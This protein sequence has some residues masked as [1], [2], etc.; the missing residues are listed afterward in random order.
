MQQTHPYGDGNTYTQCYAYDGMRRLT[1]AWTPADNNCATGPSTPGG[2]APYA[3]IDTFDAIGN[4]T[5]RTATNVTGA[6]TT[7]TYTYD[8]AAGGPSAHQL[9]GMTATGAEPGTG[10]FAYDA[11]GNTTTRD[12]IDRAPQTLSWDPVGRLAAVSVDGNAYASFVYTADGDRLIRREAGVT[13]LYLPGGQELTYTGQATTATRYYGF[14]GQTIAVRTGAGYSDVTTLISDP[15]G[16]AQIAVDNGDN[17]ITRRYFDP[18][19]QP[20]TGGDDW[21]GDHGFLNKPTDDTG[22]TQI[23]ARYYDPTIGRFISVDPI[24]DLADPQQWQGYAYANNNPVTYSDPTGLKAKKRH[25]SHRGLKKARPAVPARVTAAEVECRPE[26]PTWTE[27]LSTAGD[28]GLA[29]L[30]EATGTGMT[31]GLPLGEG[32]VPSVVYG[33]D[34]IPTSMVRDNPIDIWNRNSLTSPGWLN[35]GKALP[36]LDLAMIGAEGVWNYNVFY[37]DIEDGGE[38]LAHTV[39]RTVTESGAGIVAGTAVFA[40]VMLIA[41]PFTAGTTC[42]LAVVATATVASGTAGYVAENSAGE[43][44]DSNLGPLPPKHFGSLGVPGKV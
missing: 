11:A 27:V 10:T 23:G 39:G 5:S 38:R 7:T 12:A 29:F 26:R 31:G 13:T 37:A 17:Q 2:P 30:A 35:A 42:G 43:W 18:Y 22:L 25:W 6:R 20:L 44:Y 24:M 8:T 32:A 21:A 33:A 14:N 16:T 40:G 3:F 9:L 4:R 28:G 34:G 41:C 36:F 15:Q 19:G 1:S